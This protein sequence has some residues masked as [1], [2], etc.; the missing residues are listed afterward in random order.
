MLGGIIILLVVLS[1]GLLVRRGKLGYLVIG[2]FAILLFSAGFKSGI[3]TLL[4]DL[5]GRIALSESDQGQYVVTYLH[6]VDLQE[7]WLV[8]ILPAVAVGY[9][10]GTVLRRMRR[11]ESVMTLLRSHSIQKNDRLTVGGVVVGYVTIGIGVILYCIIGITTGNIDRGMVYNEW[12][13]QDKGQVF[14]LLTSL[15]RARDCFYIMTPFVCKRGGVYVRLFGGCVATFSIVTA[16]LSGGRGDTLY[17]V[18]MFAFGYLLCNK[19][20]KVRLLGLVATLGVVLFS[21]LPVLEA[22]RDSSSF[23]KSRLSSPTERIEA[24]LGS[25]GDLKKGIVYRAPQIGRQIYACS[26][27]FLFLDRNS[28]YLDYGFSDIRRIVLSLLP[29][30]L[31][32]DVK[33][34]DGSEIAQ[35]LIGVDRPGWFPCISLPAD[36]YRRGGFRSVFL[37]G[38]TYWVAIGVLQVVWCGLIT[39]RKFTVFSVYIA[40]LPLTYIRNYPLGTISETAWMLG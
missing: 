15:L 11:R 14:L 28:E 19:V 9:L 40:I 26:D 21:L 18:V 32:G 23:N 16:I 2:P 25:F 34:F 27:P 17:P 29:S 39:A 20:Q 38:V 3:G 5:L 24:I 35:K 1:I 36:L 8:F 12:I 10:A 13:D 33:T 31:A 30:R 7:I 37:G 22:I 4:V 6:R